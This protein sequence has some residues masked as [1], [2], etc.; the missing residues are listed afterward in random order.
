[1]CVAQYFDRSAR[2]RRFGSTSLPCGHRLHIAGTVVDVQL[3]NLETAMRTGQAQRHEPAGMRFRVEPGRSGPWTISCNGPM[4]SSRTAFLR[5]YAGA[6]KWAW[7]A[8]SATWLT[9]LL[10][11]GSTCFAFGARLSTCQGSG[12]IGGHL[13]RAVDLG[14]HPYHGTSGNQVAMVVPG[15]SDRVGTIISG[16]T[17][18]FTGN[19]RAGAGVCSAGSSTITITPRKHGGNIIL[20]HIAEKLDQTISRATPRSV[21]GRAV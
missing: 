1:M 19:P 21:L 14:R 18:R 2:I 6:R 5:Q 10:P 16:I 3:T 17:N 8:C 9:G 4:T 20:A 15:R 13:R 11:A 7:T 12:Q